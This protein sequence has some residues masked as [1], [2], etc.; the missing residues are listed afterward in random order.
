METGSNL[1][2]VKFCIK[3]ADVGGG[4]VLKNSRTWTRRWDRC[5]RNHLQRGQSQAHTSRVASEREL[6]TM[7]KEDLINVVEVTTTS[8]RR[9]K[10][11]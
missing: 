2:R 4:L 5:R 1:L 7:N 8:D 3:G 11:I 9:K 6:F 10:R